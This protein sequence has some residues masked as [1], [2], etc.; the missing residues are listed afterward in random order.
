MAG[1]YT[2]NTAEACQY[3]AESA[4]TNIIVVENDAQLQKILQVKSKLPMLKAI[5]QYSGDV[6]APN[7][8]GFI[9]TVSTSTFI[10]IVKYRKYSK[11]RAS[12]PCSRL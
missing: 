12:C 4:K 3:V 1:I 10:H 9:Y 7:A 2:T 11:S 6:V 8:K 5:V